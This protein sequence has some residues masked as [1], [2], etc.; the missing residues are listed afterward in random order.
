MAYCSHY[1]DRFVFTFVFN[2][3]VSS[4][5]FFAVYFYFLSSALFSCHF[6]FFF[7]FLEVSR[8]F[9]HAS[10]LFDRRAHYT[11]ASTASAPH[12]HELPCLWLQCATFSQWK[13][14]SPVRM[15]KI[16]WFNCGNFL[17]S[18]NGCFALYLSFV[19]WRVLLVSMHEVVFEC[20]AKAIQ[21]FIE[22]Q[23][24]KERENSKQSVLE[25]RR[26]TN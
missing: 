10:K 22:K 24:E 8:A 19:K 18:N 20:N 14:F 23:Q 1:S 9:F 7:Q 17:N 13:F 16:I 11:F 4:V 26:Q 25:M 12:I 2:L 5:R 15:I 6:E 3:A 21:L